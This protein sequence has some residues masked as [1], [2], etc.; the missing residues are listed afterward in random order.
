MFERLQF[1]TGCAPEF[2][3]ELQHLDCERDLVDHALSGSVAT[4]K[5]FEIVD[6]IVLAVA[7]LVMDCFV[8]MKFAAK[9]LFHD[10]AVFE[11]SSTFSAANQRWQMNP[12]IAMAFDMTPHLA[13]LKSSQGFL[14]K[15]FVFA[16]IAAVFLFF[17]KTATRFSA[18]FNQLAASFTIKSASFGCRFHAPGIGALARTVQWIVTVFYVVGVQVRTH[19]G[20]RF[21]A[22]FASKSNYFPTWSGCRRFFVE[23]KCTSAPETT[24]ASFIARKAD[25]RL[26]AFFTGFLNRH[27]FAPLLGSEGSLAVSVGNVK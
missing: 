9:V 21:A 22:F 6:R 24:K 23:S 27:G 11:H 13:T 2:G 19:H 17:V 3:V 18:F 10:I 25:K 5:Q 26:A 14:S 8:F 15:R 12:D 7:I 4:R 16:V 1:E 20:E